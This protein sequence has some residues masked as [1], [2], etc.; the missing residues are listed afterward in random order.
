MTLAVE[1]AHRL[2]YVEADG[3]LALGADRRFA[4][5]PVDPHRLTNQSP[6]PS[7]YGLDADSAGGQ[8]A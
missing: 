7:A 6:R 2:R 1:R 3:G 8:S 5:T 4:A